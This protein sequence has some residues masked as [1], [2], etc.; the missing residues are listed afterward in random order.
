MLYIYL[1]MSYQSGYHIRE[2][3]GIMGIQAQFSAVPAT[4]VF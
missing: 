3:V 1:L 2:F 4:F